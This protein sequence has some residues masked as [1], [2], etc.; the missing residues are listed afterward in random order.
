MPVFII[1][2]VGVPPGTWPRLAGQIFLIDACHHLNFFIMGPALS[3]LHGKAFGTEIYAQYGIGWPLVAAALS[4]LSALTY[5]NLV[6]LEIVYCCVYYLALFFLLRSCFKRELW[7][8]LAVILVIY[9]QVFSGLNSNEVVWLF[10][11]S[12]PMRHPMDVW[13]FL[14]LVMHQRSGTMFWAIAAGFAGALGVLLDRKSTRL[15]SSHLGISY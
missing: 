15:N 2:A 6:G 4:R 9:W 3:F 7:A 14:A 8:A 13:F 10:P 11:S 12:T 5:A 1:L